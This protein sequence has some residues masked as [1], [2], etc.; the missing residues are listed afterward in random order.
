M[1]NNLLKTEKNEERNVVSKLGKMVLKLGK[2]GWKN[3]KR[4]KIDFSFIWFD[5]SI[6]DKKVKKF[7]RYFLGFGWFTSWK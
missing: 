5:F 1:K 7:H 6:N 2:N 3:I 4:G